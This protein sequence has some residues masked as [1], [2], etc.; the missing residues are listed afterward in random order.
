MPGERDQPSPRKQPRSASAPDAPPQGGSSAGGAP[1]ALTTPLNKVLSPKATRDLRTLGLTNV[2]RLVAY[3]PMRHEFQAAE[4]RIADLVLDQIV[5]ARGLVTATR[6]SGRGARSRFQAVVTDD[7]GRLDVTWFHGAYLKDRVRPGVRVRLQGKLTR[8]GPL[9]ELANPRVEVLPEVGDEPQARAERLRPVYP[10]S[11]I[12][13]SHRIE[14]AVERVLDA[15]LGLIDDHL[16][17]A[18]RRERGLVALGEAYRM[19]HRPATMEEVGAARRR[20]AYDELL[21]LQ[22]GVHM[23]RAHLRRALKAPALRFNPEIDRHI[24]ERL[25]FTLTPGQEDAVRDL[26]QDLQRATPTNR[27]IQGDVGSGKTVVALYAMLLAVADKH[28][29][30]LMAPTELLAEQHLGSIS[31][32]LA[33]SRVRVELLTGSTPGAERARILAGLARGTVDILIGTHAVLGDGVVFKSLG[34][35]VVDEQHRFGVSQRAILRE[36]GTGAAAAGDTATPHVVVMTATPIPR[37]LALTLFGDLDISVIKG[38]PPGRRAIATHWWGMN[39]RDEAYAIVRQRLE[40]GEQA[41]I[42]A[43]AIGDDG[44]VEP[45]QTGGAENAPEEGDGG[46]SGTRPAPSPAPPGSSVG[47]G[48]PAVSFTPGGAGGSGAPIRDVLGLLKELEHGPLKGLRLATLH[49]QLKRDQR[50]KIMARFR[51][52]E[53]Q[54]LVATTVIEVGVDVPNAGVMVVEQADRFGLAQL[55][56]LRGRVGRGHRDSECYFLADPATEDGAARLRVMETTTDGFVLA[57]EDLAIRG[58]GEVFG[59]RQS[60]LPPFKVA[61]LAKDLDLLGMARRDAAEWIDRSPTL[62]GQDEGVL[63]RRV[64]KTH[65]EALGLADVG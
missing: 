5:S 2:G 19:M 6:V 11:E 63:L 41:Y 25:A 42:V 36:R 8:Y 58:P 34:V 28:Q 45:L 38:L 39:R 50:D 46:E 24:R 12:I 56:Q 23:K 40:R 64:R 44:A 62:S 55:H 29:A 52:G 49:G 4:A 22:L 61:D 33:G 21:L 53:I 37:S 9:L 26:A 15:A 20:L 54:A 18:F 1:F 31:R 47:R 35:A 13:N 27:L 7:S 32:A 60:G 17:E 43:P 16:P 51:A 59:T 57:E 30:M 48:A 3:L 65:G 10:A 14:Q